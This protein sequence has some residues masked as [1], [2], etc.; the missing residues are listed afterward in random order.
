MREAENLMTMLATLGYA[1][2]RDIDTN[3]HLMKK[4]FKGKP[5]A[6]ILID[7]YGDVITTKHGLNRLLEIAPLYD[8]ILDVHYNCL[9]VIFDSVKNRKLQYVKNVVYINYST[10]KL[11]HGVLD[12]E[13]SEDLA[14][15][16]KLLAAD[17]KR[18]L[19]TEDKISFSHT[20]SDHRVF[21]TYLIIVACVII[22]GY[23]IGRYNIW[24]ISRT[25]F[26][27]GERYR[28]LSYMFVHGSI[29]HLISNMISLCI[30][31]KVVEKELGWYNLAFIYLASGISGA[32]FTMK[33]SGTPYIYTVGASGAICGLIAANMIYGMFLPKARRGSMVFS[34]GI[35]RRDLRSGQLLS[36]RRSDRWIFIGTVR[37]PCKGN[38]L[39]V[40]ACGSY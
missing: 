26:E 17:A 6:I 37:L 31:G 2:G 4:G 9:V 10:G 18:K 28:L 19:Y 16:K 1:R 38:H 13:F 34:S 3:V 7:N 29:I 21:L 39:R 23:T 33:Y 27:S 22:F 8:E 14:T 11:S 24:G 30:I 36:F 12:S 32:F 40:E 35:W 15:I 5:H 20:Y 25:A